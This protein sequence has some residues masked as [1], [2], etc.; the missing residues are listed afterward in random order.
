MVH[1]FFQRGLHQRLGFGVER[2][3]C[4][5]EQQKRRIAQDRT[6]DRNALAL[7]AGQRD[8][9][10]AKRRIEAARQTW[11]AV[12]INTAGGLIFIGA[13]SYDRKFRAFDSRTGQLLWETEL[14]FAAG[15]TPAT[16][17]IDGKQYVVIASSGG[18][19]PK[20]PM[21]GMYIAFSLP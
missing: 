3:G 10:L 14:P 15:A 5:V 4:F 21:G 6:R 12:M 16:Y 13:T 11:P 8:A 2:R 1:Q 9:A 20:S 17:S 18:R 7:A 19:D